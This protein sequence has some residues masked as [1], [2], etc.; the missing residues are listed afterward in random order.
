VSPRRRCT[1]IAVSW[2]TALAR[3]VTPIGLRPR[4][5]GDERGS[6]TIW[7]LSIIVMLT[8]AMMLALALAAAVI[9]RHRATSAADLAALA[10]AGQVLAGPA[11]A[12]GRAAEI[13]RRHGAALERCDVGATSVAVEVSLPHEL[14]WLGRQV[15]APARGRA[16]AGV[17]P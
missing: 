5:R 3:T 15:L 17:G 6:A 14:G 11:A 12:C 9:Q 10:G 4:I 2:R 7:S 1:V 13:A 8:A 16:R